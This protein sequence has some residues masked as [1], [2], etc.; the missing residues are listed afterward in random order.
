MKSIEHKEVKS[1]F[2]HSIGYD[3]ESK[4]M[5]VALKSGATYTYPDIEPHVHK[6]IIEAESVGKAFG[7]L[8]GA[9]NRK[10]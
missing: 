10:K 4:T 8:R 9:A 2:I 7:Q 6:G 5:E 3:A 1:S